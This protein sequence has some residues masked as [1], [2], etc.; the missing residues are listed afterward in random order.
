[1]TSPPMG[2]SLDDL[3]GL[4]AYLESMSR[5]LD[6]ATGKRQ[7]R[8]AYPTSYVDQFAY[9]GGPRSAPTIDGG[10]VYTLGAESKLHCL[11]LETGKA[12]WSRNL[13]AEYFKEAKQKL[14]E[15]FEKDYL[16]ALLRRNNYNISKTA[17]EAGIDRKHIRNLL[18][19]YGILGTDDEG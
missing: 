5:R 8:F 16:A 12:L 3:C 15:G 2:R 13:H 9:N 19:K 18:K 17:R 6:P 1:V 7:W 10:K 14:V 11:D 4:G